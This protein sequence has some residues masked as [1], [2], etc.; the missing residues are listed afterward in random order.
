M[1]LAAY[2][3]AALAAIKGGKT[4]GKLAERFDLHPNQSTQ[5]RRQPLK[6]AS[7]VLDALAPSGAA[8]AVDVKTLHAKIGALTLEDGFLSNA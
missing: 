6:G 2:D 4:L 8:P 7:G 3:R 1:F 5:W